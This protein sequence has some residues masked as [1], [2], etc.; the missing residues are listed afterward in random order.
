[1]WLLHLIVVMMMLAL[2]LGVM[3]RALIR[4]GLGLRLEG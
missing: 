1:M 4:E 3:L 2:V